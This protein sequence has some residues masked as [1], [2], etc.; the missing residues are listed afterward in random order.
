MHGTILKSLQKQAKHIHAWWEFTGRPDPG[1]DGV[2]ESL[3]RLVSGVLTHP[4]TIGRYNAQILNYSF[5]NNSI[6]I[7]KLSGKLVNMFIT[8][9]I[10][11]SNLLK[12][13]KILLVV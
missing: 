9:C 1:E 8:K 2:V 3:K 4:I 12:Y 13:G 11:P 10:L 6:M 5:S 7:L